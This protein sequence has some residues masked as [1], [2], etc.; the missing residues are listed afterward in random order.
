MEDT[1]VYIPIDSTSLT[2]TGISPYSYNDY[3]GLEGFPVVI[4]NVSCEGNEVKLID[5]PYITGGSGSAVSLECSYSGNNT[6][7]ML[8]IVGERERP[9]FGFWILCLLL[10]VCIDS[11]DDSYQIK[12]TQ[13]FNTHQKINF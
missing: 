1:S 6:R 2:Y 11:I 13:N 3:Y 7:R 4:S 8:N 5:C 10:F 9:N 12:N